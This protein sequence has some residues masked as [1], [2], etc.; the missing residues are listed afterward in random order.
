M[1]KIKRFVTDLKNRPNIEPFLVTQEIPKYGIYDFCYINKNPTTFS[2][3][4]KKIKDNKYVDLEEFISQ[5]RQ[6]FIS[7]GDYAFEDDPIQGLVSAFQR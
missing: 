7:I 6:V 5:L 2:K 4:D 3:I 1:G